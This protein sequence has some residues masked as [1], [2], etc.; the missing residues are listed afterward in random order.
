[1]LKETN[2]KHISQ[3]EQNEKAKQ[4]TQKRHRSEPKFTLN[5]ASILEEKN[6]QTRF[7]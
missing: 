4:S 7:H 5:K 3:C 1:M 2:L 6:H